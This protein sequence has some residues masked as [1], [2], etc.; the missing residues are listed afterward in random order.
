MARS[1]ECAPRFPEPHSASARARRSS[2][3]RSSRASA[4]GRRRCCWPRPAIPSCSGPGGSSGSRRR[5]RRSWP[6]GARPWRCRSTSPTTRPIDAFAER[7]EAE[8]GPIEIVVSNAGDVLPATALE[9]DP[10]D[11]ARQVQVNVLGAHRLVRAPRA[12]DGR[13]PA[14]RHRLRHLRRRAR[15][16]HLHGRLRHVQERPRGPGPCHADGAGGHRRAGRASCAPARRPPS[17]APP[18]ARRPSTRSIA[19]WERWGVLRHSGALRAPGRRPRHPH[20]RVHAPRHA[21][22]PRRGGA[23]SPRL[24]GTA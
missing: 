8:L 19:D 13:A 3:A 9:V 6:P 20:R 22:H 14:R 1:A 5:R 21:P 11:F 7:A 23:R 10:D 16:A 12:R 24:G 4:P 18:G 17:R 2:P 15:A